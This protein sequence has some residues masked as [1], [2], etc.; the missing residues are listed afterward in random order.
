MNISPTIHSLRGRFLIVTTAD[1][2]AGSQITH[3]V[4]ARRRWRIHSIYFTLIT[5]A[6]VIDRQARIRLNDGGIVLST[7]TSSYTQAA[8]LTYAYTFANFGSTQLNP[9]DTINIPLGPCCLPAGTTIQSQIANLQ[10]ADNLSAANLLVEEW[11][12]P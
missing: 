10:A 1:P 12:D 6:T 7:V 9:T 8:S 2:A 4:P 5:D 3:P 11:I